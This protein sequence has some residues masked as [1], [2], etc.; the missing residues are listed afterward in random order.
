MSEGINEA[1]LGSTLYLTFICTIR[2][3]PTDHLAPLDPSFT[4]IMAL[5]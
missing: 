1:Q 2:G 3:G 5:C 4:D